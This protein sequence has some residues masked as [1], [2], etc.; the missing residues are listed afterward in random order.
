MQILQ[1]IAAFHSPGFRLYFIGNA[2]ALQALWIQRTTLAWLAW[3][4]SGSASFV[5]WVAFLNFAPVMLTG[6]L[7]GALVDRAE[8]RRAAAMAQFAMF[9]ISVAMAGSY[10]LG[11][12]STTLLLG[13]AMSIGIVTS[14]HH[15]IRM[16]LAP[17]LVPREAIGS[18]SSAA[19]INFN[20]ARSVGPAIAGMLI[21]QF[22]IGTGLWAIVALS[23]PYQLILPFLHPRE[24]QYSGAPDMGLFAALASGFGL[25]I[26]SPFIRTVLAIT[27]ANAV[28]GRGLL[29]LMP[30]IADGIY[31]QGPAGLGILT[32]ATGLGALCA[33]GLSVILPRQPAGTVPLAARIAAFC[34]LAVSA[35][36]VLGDSW[37]L[38]V[39]A[40]AA[41]GAT[42]TVIG[43]T[44]QAA[45]LPTL[46]DDY[47]GRVM[48][49][50]VMTGIGSA[51]LGALL[52]GSLADLVGLPTAVLSVGGA[53]FFFL[54]TA[55]RFLR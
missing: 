35:V 17:L 7:F 49:L 3:D 28:V 40:A 42:G 19:A 50:W 33:A 1:N 41:L 9:T 6:P 39:A 5:G 54:L 32:S 27:A 13:F 15:P 10:G 18:V 26:K 51:A 52:L 14:A 21:A 4:L 55:P 11:W 25:A 20:L 44:M 37:P 38:T 22:G 24:R 2:F 45:L 16:S 23:L 46:P 31:K 30:L 12:M 36:L 8:V 48:S 53:A 29:E 47:R 34:G 43:I